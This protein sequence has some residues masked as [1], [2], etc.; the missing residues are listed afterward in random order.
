MSIKS[1]IALVLVFVIPNN[2]G[3]IPKVLLQE[4]YKLVRV[5]VCQGYY[6][7]I[8]VSLLLCY[9]DNAETRLF[10]HLLIWLLQI[11]KNMD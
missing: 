8:R 6:E 7:Y 1:F 9:K 11:E 10:G 2:T 5:S 4:L 3:D